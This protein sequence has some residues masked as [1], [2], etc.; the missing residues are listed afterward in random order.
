VL[1]KRGLRKKINN[2]EEKAIKKNDHIKCTLI[3]RGGEKPWGSK[4]LPK[5]WIWAEERYNIRKCRPRSK[6]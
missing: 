1:A 3:S 4:C 5:D 6:N 2:D